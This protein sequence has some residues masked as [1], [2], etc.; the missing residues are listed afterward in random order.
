MGPSNIERE[1][2]RYTGRVWSVFMEN[3]EHANLS[4]VKLPVLSK[5]KFEVYL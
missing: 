2:D 3:F 4:D 5:C 1:S